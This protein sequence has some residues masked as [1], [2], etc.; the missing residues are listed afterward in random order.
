MIKFDKNEFLKPQIY[1]TLDE[2]ESRCNVTKEIIKEIEQLQQENEQLKEELKYTVPI[3]EHNKI[4]SKKLKENQKYKEVI[5][6]VRNIAYEYG[7]ID[8]AHHKTWVIDQMI[9]ELLG[10]EYDNFIKEYEEDGEYTWDI[11]IAP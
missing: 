11:G 3:V 1:S 9:R 8:G 2:Y 6:K 5:D 7:Q 10:T 4:V